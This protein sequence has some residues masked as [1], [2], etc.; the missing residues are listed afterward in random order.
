M[1]SIAQLQ[2]RSIARTVALAALL[3][4]ATMAAQTGQVIGGS[5]LSA[6]GD[7]T[8]WNTSSVQAG[9]QIGVSTLNPRLGYGGYGSASLEMSVTGQASGG[10]YPDWAFWYRYQDGSAGA[11]KH[12][13]PGFGSL[14]NLSSMSFDWY[15]AYMPGWNA[16]SVAGE[17]SGEAI[18]P[19]DWAYKTPVVR[20]QLREERNGVL[21]FSELIWEG[22]YNQCS[23]GPSVN[24]AENVTP[25][26]TWVSQ[27]DMQDDNF[28]Y[29]RHA[30]VGEVAQYG[31]KGECLESMSFWEG[32]ITA[33]S[34]SGLFGDGGCFS[35]ATVD[36]I[37]IAVGVGSQW[38]LPYHA[39]VD[40][41]RLGFGGS[42]LQRGFADES[43][44]LDANFDM[45][46]SSAVPEPSSYALMAAG[47]MAVGAVA[48]RR[49]GS[50]RPE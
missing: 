23:L 16:P 34:T 41:V 30:E 22:Y 43:Y 18:P 26:D 36:V 38:P 50:A 37:G 2:L 45:I 7:T 4:P 13:M 42:E 20:L 33:N 29:I 28:W 39:F 44:S 31:Q 6:L 35:A 24:C 40:N 5:G 1:F 3:A 8:S 11:S 21:T 14:A 25:I 27:S 17:P 47:L 12:T 10:E 9:G 48:R 19:I 46:P 32:G 49:R 15:R